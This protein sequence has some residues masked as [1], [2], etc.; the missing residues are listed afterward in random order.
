MSCGG[1]SKSSGSSA[2]VP[3]QLPGRSSESRPSRVRRRWCRPRRRPPGGNPRGSARCTCAA[4]APWSRA[5]AGARRRA[6]SPPGPRAA[7]TPTAAPA[8]APPDRPSAAAP[9]PAARRAPAAEHSDRAA[10]ASHRDHKAALRATPEMGNAARGF[11]C[12]QSKALMGCWE[13]QRA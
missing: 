6:G 1:Q 9:P 4:A 2:A 8:C 13:I 12:T 3:R 5:R 10:A 11:V 7:G